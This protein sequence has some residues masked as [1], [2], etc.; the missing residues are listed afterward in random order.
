LKNRNNWRELYPFK[1][2]YLQLAENHL[3]YI[4][5]G[6]EHNE[7]VL[8]V[9]GNPT[10]SFY[11][12][13]L[14]VELQKKY[15]VIVPDHMGCGLSDKPQKYQYTLKQ[16]IE[17]LD[18]LMEKQLKI[19]GKI[20]LIVHDWGGAI[21]MGYAVQHHKKIG[22]ITILNTAAFL[23]PNC[24][25]RIKICKIPIFGDIV[26]RGFNAFAKLALNMAVCT[27][28]SK[29]VQSGLIAPYNNYH[30]RIATLRFV[31]DIPLKSSHQTWQIL[32]G[33]QK[34]L[35]LLADKKIII[36]WGGKD[37]CFN[38][39]FLKV[40][41]QYFPKAELNYYP[42]AGHYILEDKKAEIIPIIN[43]FILKN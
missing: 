17:N 11:F 20:H 38:D 19:T 13:D 18:I 22:K 29:Q 8:M 31:Q 1:S 42:D 32:V 10:W 16:H 23:S 35:N 5:E 27:K 7:T 4:D 33:I 26:I 41:Q 25:F 12:R 37:F 36:C 3:H 39:S 2:N 6:S 15:R 34:K 24:P 40:W 21:G 9:H 43:N 30:N 14:I 28:M